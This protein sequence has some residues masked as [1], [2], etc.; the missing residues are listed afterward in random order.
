MTSRSL[1]ASNDKID[2]DIAQLHAGGKIEI[3]SKLATF[4]PEELA[5][6]YT[7]GVAQ[8]CMA[9]HERP[10]AVRDYTIKA[11]T[12]AVVTDGT[13]VLGLGNI[14]PAAA[15]P[16]M[17]GKALLFKEFAGIDA[18]PICLDV[19][20]LPKDGEPDRGVDEIVETV[21]RLAPGFG[22]IN[23]ED[24]AAPRCFA[25]ERAL[26]EQ[27]DIPVFHDDQHGTAVVTL[28]ALQNALRVVK[29]ELYNVKVVVAG[30]GAAGAAITKI[31][32]GG[33]ARHVVVCD[34]GGALYRERPGMTSEKRWLAEH[35]NPNSETGS[36]RDVVRDAD[37]FV[38][39]SGPNLL[40]RDDVKSMAD[41]SVVFALANPDPEVAP[42]D[43]IG[44]AAVYAT[45]RSDYPNQINNVLCYPGVF[46]G[47]I[48]SGARAITEE[49][50]LAAARAIAG[51]VN[52]GELDATNIMPS[53]FDPN[54][55]RAVAHAVAKAAD[56][57][58]V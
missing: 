10:S 56:F 38:G 41:D 31:L 29:K 15:L 2:P 50:K 13:A 34:R 14:G 22:G 51:C 21:L 26:R 30:A 46:R 17:E 23:L 52:E 47:A 45:G 35:T 39:V 53:V 36:L 42:S 44:I 5:K 28:A 55:V 11:N 1:E 54:V 40:N 24:I 25:V 8:A 7:P 3:H 58:Q 4:G 49:M 9:I 12:V 57:H 6:V 32:L 48:D 20:P 33:G 19:S 37:V 43:A 18:F 27:L 16:V